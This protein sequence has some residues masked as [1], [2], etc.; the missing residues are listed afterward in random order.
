MFLKGFLFRADFEIGQSFRL[1]FEFEIP[2]C[3]FNF[4]DVTA[5][6][7]HLSERLLTSSQQLDV[8]RTVQSLILSSLS[9]V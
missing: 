9:I 4:Q 6:S 1:S 7:C 2:N 5:V 3:P 8:Q